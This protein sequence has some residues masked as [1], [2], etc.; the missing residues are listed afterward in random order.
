MMKSLTMM[1][2]ARMPPTLTAGDC[3]KGTCSL[4]QLVDLWHQHSGMLTCFNQAPEM[5]GLH[6]DRFGRTDSGDVCR[7]EWDLELPPQILVRRE[8]VPILHTGDMAKGHLGCLADRHWLVH[9]DDGRIALPDS[10]QLGGHLDKIAFVWLLRK[11]VIFIAPIPGQLVA[12]DDW[13][14][15]AAWYVYHEHY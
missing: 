3:E 12:K 1:W 5:L 11:D 6:I 7:A 10:D 2:A 15:K 4:Q 9:H 13:I 14:W 8:Y